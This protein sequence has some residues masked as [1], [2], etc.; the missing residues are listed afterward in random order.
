MKSFTWTSRIAPAG[1]VGKFRGSIRTA[2]IKALACT[3]A[4]ASAQLATP[5]G[6][7]K[8]VKGNVVVRVG[9]AARRVDVLVDGEP[10][11]SYIW[12]ETLMKPVLFPLRT[13]RGTV[14]T[15]GFPL[16]PRAG[17]SVDHPHQV[18]LWLNYGDVEG[19]D[20][21]NNSVYRTAAERARMGT[22]THRR[23]LSAKGGKESGELEVEAEW[24]MPDGKVALLETTRFV[25]RAGR[26][27]RAVD[28]ITTLRALG[29]YGPVKLG[30]SK[31]GLLG[32]RVRRELE[33][34]ALKPILLTDAEGRTGK[35][36]VLDNRNVTGRYL[37][38]EG[39]TGDDVWGTRARWAV[40]LGRVGEEP[41]TLAIMDHPG[42]INHPTHWMARGYGL[43]AANSLGSKA[44]ETGK[45]AAA[46][47]SLVL[48]PGD[49][50]TFRYRLLILSREATAAEMEAEYKR[51]VAEVK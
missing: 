44:Y 28:R 34:P 12:P 9:E 24:R 30:D 46:E 16:E 19:V 10:F 17:E 7:Q 45:E 2:L 38:S 33:Q 18:G 41:I 14:V 39:K 20:F 3:F 31:E 11:T 5:A 26:D 48:K 42:N 1:F 4:L 27:S 36:P 8:V 40:L 6:A 43:F 23:V 47:G 13:A 29:E 35:T 32:L 50:V 25:F 21:W 49:S 51:F 22:I 15:R 37:S